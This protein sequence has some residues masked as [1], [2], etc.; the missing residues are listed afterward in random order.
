MVANTTHPNY[1]PGM[2]KALAFVTN[3][4]GIASHAAIVARE[5]KKPCVVGTKNATSIFK[6]G[7]TVEVDAD[8]GIA[9]LLKSRNV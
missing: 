5:L 8:Q 2:Q 7:D 1:L 6:D 4:G 9:R 3:E